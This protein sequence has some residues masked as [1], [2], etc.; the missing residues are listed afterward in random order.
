LQHKTSRYCRTFF[1]LV[2]KEKALN[3]REQ[4]GG[5]TFFLLNFWHRASLCELRFMCGFSTACPSKKSIQKKK[6][7]RGTTEKA[8]A[9]G[10]E[11]VVQR[12]S[13]GPTIA[14]YKKQP[15]SFL[16]FLLKKERTNLSTEKPNS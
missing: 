10:A 16:F 4:E 2:E 12:L 1:F 11:E 13:S 6:K 15:C 9:M 7:K 3:A 8:G 5:S 14:S